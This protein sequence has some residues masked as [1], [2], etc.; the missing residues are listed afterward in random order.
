[1]IRAYVPH[2]R[3]GAVV[4]GGLLGLEAAKALLDLGLSQT[5]IIEFAPRLMARQI[6]NAGSEPLEHKLRSLGRQIHK[7]KC[8]EEILGEARITGVKCSGQSSLHTDLLIFSAGIKPRD[9]LAREA[10][11]EV[12]SRGGIVVNDALQTSDSRIFAIGECACVH[13]MIYGLV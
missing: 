7:N 10:G 6:D 5:H 2:A 4:G 8:A 9:E 11:L 3:S 13:N 1:K 12:H